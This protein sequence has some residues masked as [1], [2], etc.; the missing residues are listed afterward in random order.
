MCFTNFVKKC[1]VLCFA[2]LC[3]FSANH[4]FAKNS[5][6]NAIIGGQGDAP[7][8]ALLEPDGSLLTLPGLPAT[9]LTYRVAINPSGEGIIGGTNAL[10]AYAALV[11]PNGSLTP[12]AGLLAPGEIYTVAIN[13]SGT[14]IIGG[15]HLASNIPYAA[16]VAPNG[17]AASFAGL[18]ANGLIYSVAIDNSGGGIIGGI[19]PLNSA[20]AA[21]I[22]S[23]G[24]LTPLIGLPATG[25]IFW[26]AVN[27]SKTK[28]IG[29]QAN[30][31]VYAAFV[32]PNGSLAPIANL[33]LGLN[34]SVAINASGAGIMGGSSLSLPYAA[35]VAPNGSVTTLNGLPTTTGII[36]TVSINDSGTGLIAGFSSSGPYGTFT[37]PDGT[38]TPLLGLPSGAGFLDGVA[39]HSSGAGLVG[40]ESL[41]S[42]FAALVAP[43]GTLTYLSGLPMHGAINSSAIAMLNNLVPRSIGPFDSWANTQFTLADTLTQHCMIHHTNWFKNT[44]NRNGQVACFEQHPCLVDAAKEET[45]SL[46]MALFG[47]YVHEKAQHA[48]PSFSNKITGALL[49]LDYK[50][51]QD[52]VIGGGLAYAFNYVHYFE[53]LG[54]AAI[55]QESAVLYASLNKSHFYMNAAL[56]GG[57]SQASNKR[58]SFTHI[59]SKANPSGWNLSPHLE[60][61]APFPITQCENFVIDP[62]VTF[63]WAH[64]WQCHFR[65]RGSSGFNIVLNNQYA[66]VFRS[67]IGFRF[68]ETLQYGWGHL[69]IEEKVSY[70]NKTPIRRGIGTA[71]FIGAASSF[72]VETFNPSTQNQGTAQ[73]HIECI[74]SDLENLYASV[75][76]Q[77]EFGSSFQSHML[78]F[79]MGKN[80]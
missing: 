23:S 69:I 53:S 4:V 9:G 25:S 55:N 49:A 36:Y 60:L 67:E 43:N 79:T 35:L 39:L 65:E 75:D 32:A 72:D 40:G 12:I 5:G 37:A 19:G 13:K 29:G 57:V 64:N 33:P 20:Y 70:I 7:Y 28:L 30:S 46:W 71:S 56:W 6:P 38:L 15:G 59:T 51:I 54:H 77:G 17:I 62:F 2:A 63:D 50:G 42:P 74:P 8:A 21:L 16:L 41:G 68:Y 27:D 66:S 44:M 52:V 76:Y 26:V 61:S 1:G 3:S 80:F 48:I 78:I 73:I 11:S 22:S 18:P 34:Y 47:N 45:S 10:N 14:G 58:R 24:I 31:S